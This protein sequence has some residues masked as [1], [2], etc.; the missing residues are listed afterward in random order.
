MGKRQAPQ[1]KELGHVSVAQLV[2]DATQQHLKKD[3]CRDFNKVERGACPLIESPPTD[4]TPKHG[5][6]Q[7]SLTLEPRNAGRVT[8]RTIHRG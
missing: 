3:V 8:V 1:Q 6:P 5:I 2:A 7:V 4:F